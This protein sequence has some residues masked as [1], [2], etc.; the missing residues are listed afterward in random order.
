VK[1]AGRERSFIA[2]KQIWHMEDELGGADVSWSKQAVASEPQQLARVPSVLAPR[3][4]LLLALAE[5]LARNYYSRHGP[6][7]AI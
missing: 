2:L 5:S 1:R 6:I 7:S 3:F 4:L